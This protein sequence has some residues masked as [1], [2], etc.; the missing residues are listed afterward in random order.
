VNSLV[1][2]IS[3][4]H[5]AEAGSFVGASRL[6]GLSASAVG[7]NVARLEASLGA[8][9]F[10]RSTRAVRLTE[11]G[12]VFYERCKRGLQELEDAQALLQAA[13]ATPRGRLRVSVPTV[14]YHFLMPHLPSF[15]TRYP[16][17]ELELDFNDRVVDLFG[18]GIDV[19]I[20]GGRLPDSALKARRLGHYRFHLCGS[21]EYLRRHGTPR[22]VAELRGHTALR[23]RL[24]STGRVQAWTL[25]DADGELEGLRDGV[26]A[27]NMEALVYAALTG[28][29][30]IHGPDFLL[31]RYVAAGQ[32]HPVLPQYRFEGGD[33]W[34]V[35]P[36]SRH[37]QPRVRAF[38]DHAVAHLFKAR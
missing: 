34:L 2:L 31:D 12:Q 10:E 8:A 18:E 27:N 30:L 24:P 7:K 29:G 35:W 5:V 32:L 11:L 3:F 37:A 15:R 6:L 22:T 19:A 21:P 9:L 28:A 38:V 17:V 16:Q 4:V 23:Y 36:S 33:F 20:R 13:T 1:G 26:V 14:G 25:A